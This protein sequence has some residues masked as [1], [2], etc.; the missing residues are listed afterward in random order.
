MA[1]EL[2]S[3]RQRNRR[4][5]SQIAPVSLL[6]AITIVVLAL[7]RMQIQA[8]R[9]FALPSTLAVFASCNKKRLG[10]LQEAALSCDFAQQATTR[11]SASDLGS[12]PPKSNAELF[13]CEKTMH[14]LFLQCFDRTSILLLAALQLLPTSRFLGGGGLSPPQLGHR[15]AV[16]CS[17]SAA[18]A[19]RSV[20]RPARQ[21]RSLACRRLEHLLVLLC[22]RC[23]EYHLW[24]L[25]FFVGH[26]SKAPRRSA[27]AFPRTCATGALQAAGHFWSTW[28]F[29]PQAPL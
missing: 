8:R 20:S 2:R 24:R 29:D 10:Q 4:R 27:G 18:A 26:V 11:L 25:Q 17:E 6:G 22:S 5:P 7:Q 23:F 13:E 12:T 21:R 28:T 16:A 9:F 3:Q 1:A 14:R 19:K 15:Q